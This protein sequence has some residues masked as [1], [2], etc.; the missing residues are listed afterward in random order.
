MSH[1][2][3]VKLLHKL[4]RRIEAQ[5][6]FRIHGALVNVLLWFALAVYFF[7]LL[8]LDGGLMLFV[9]ALGSMLF[10]MGIV[11]LAFSGLAAQQWRF[12]KPHINQGSVAARLR[13]LQS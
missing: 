10:G 1:T 7:V 12:L 2:Q 8:G 13:E 6:S 3:E 9:V 11:T 5:R 4:Q